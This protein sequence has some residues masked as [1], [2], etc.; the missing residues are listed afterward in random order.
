MIRWDDGDEDSAQVDGRVGDLYL[1]SLCRLPRPVDGREWKLTTAL[2]S[3]VPGERSL[4]RFTTSL[5]EGK[6]LA[7]QVLDTFINYLVKHGRSAG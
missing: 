1:F 5:D 2:P 4:D 7:Q 3:M 6:I